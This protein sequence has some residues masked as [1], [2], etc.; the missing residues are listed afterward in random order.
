MKSAAGIKQCRWSETLITNAD[1]EC[2]SHVYK[3]DKIMVVFC[4]EL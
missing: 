2:I 3:Y 4:C 1:T